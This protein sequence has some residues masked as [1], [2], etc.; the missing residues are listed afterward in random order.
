MAELGARLRAA[1]EQKGLSLE[2]VE[3]ATRIRRAFLEALEEERFEALPG[4]VYARGFV[5]NYALFLGL[6]AKDL[7]GAYHSRDHLPARG[8]PRVLD[9]PLLSASTA[10]QWLRLVLAL[11]I[12]VGAILAAWYG[13]RLYAVGDLERLVR[14]VLAPLLVRTPAQSTLSR[15][16][17]ATSTS[18]VV[19]PPV[20]IPTATFTPLP[21]ERALAAT[22]SVSEAPMLATPSSEPT[23]LPSPTRTPSPSPTPAI[24]I[25][26][27]GTVTATTYLEVTLDDQRT[28]TGTLNSGDS[29][30]WEAQTRI[31]LLVG[32]AAGLQLTVNGIKVAPLGREGEVVTVEYTRTALPRP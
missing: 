16:V 2:Q 12:L 20:M 22:A 29:R 19:T 17:P 15:T 6:D 24:A 32:N 23:V 7:L 9:E 26:V 28:F 4:D 1:R 3:H 25:R 27:E 18:I 13:Y 11:A 21:Q 14:P 31:V 10:R 30:T 8:M 5:R